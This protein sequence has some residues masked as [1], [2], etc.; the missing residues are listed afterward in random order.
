MW[1]KDKSKMKKKALF[2][3]TLGTA[4]LLA[5][6]VFAAYTLVDNAGKTGIRITPGNVEDEP[7]GTV[8]LDWGS[9]T[10]F[11]L[12]TGLS[13][14]DP[15]TRSIE[16]VA[17]D[18]DGALAYQG[19]LDVELQD[20]TNKA[21]GPKLIDYLHVDVYQGAATT[22]DDEDH[23]VGDIGRVTRQA[24]KTVET[25]AH[26]NIA[27]DSESGKNTIYFIISI[28][29]D[30]TPYVN[31]ITTDQVYLSVDWNRKSD[32][33]NAV[34]R[35]YIPD[36][37]WATMNVYSYDDEGKQNGDWPGVALSRDPE[38]GYFVA[39]LL[40]SHNH[41]I[42]TEASDSTD[43]RWPADG[44]GGMLRDTLN[45][46]E[47]YYFNWSTKAFTENPPAVEYSFYLV[48]ETT[49][50]WSKL[51]ANGFVVNTDGLDTDTY[52]NQWKATVTVVADK[53]YKIRGASDVDTDWFGWT[54]V[55]DQSG[56][57]I[58]V[59]A[60]DSDNFKFRT[61]GTYDLYL[62]QLKSNTDYYKI[63][64]VAK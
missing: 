35:V 24:A 27:T 37:G 45:I 58:F 63:V 6:G 40:N 5:G 42:F 28:D 60:E 41:F 21:S 29:A 1:R 52:N 13:I 39:D 38:T 12:V 16:V 49:D 30:A 64:A 56:T 19:V 9:T 26:Y 31:Q 57:S 4:V 18:D 36:N 61:A 59:N 33:T 43:H 11:N 50:S 7:V 54:S 23:F 55:E 47:G 2:F 46:H 22:V 3:S 10:N 8:T 51:A 25:S 20:L 32:S 14:G 17:T 44:E 34:T 62:K 48:G 15:A 53:A